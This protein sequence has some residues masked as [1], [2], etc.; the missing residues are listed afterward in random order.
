MKRLSLLTLYILCF[1]YYLGSEAVAGVVTTRVTGA[2]NW[3]SSSTWI[4]NRTGTISSSTLSATVTGVGTAFDVELS[5]G[6]LLVLQTAPGT[7][8][9]TIA[10]IQNATQLTLT[11]NAGANAAAQTYGRETVPTSADD[12]IIGNTALAAAVTVTL[13]VA[14]ATV[15][16]LTFTGMALANSLTHTGANNLTVVNG[17]TI[18]QPTGAAT[19]SWNINAGAASVNGGLTIGGPNATA[20]RVAQVA[21]TTGAL[22]VLGSLSFVSNTNAADE[23]ISVTTG[24]ITLNSALAMNSGTLSMTGAGTLNFNAGLTFGGVNTP[25]FSTVAASN[26]NIGGSLT[27]VTTPLALNATTNT[28][29]RKSVV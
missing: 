7:V 1:T 14:S 8:I 13:D 4:Q 12:V 3:S 21:V 29:D 24:T 19:I 25:V 18:N 23:I 27:A 26:L 11:A 28:T 5:P 2:A 9:G 6:D 20:S 15:N 22:S 17:A 10:S 16:S